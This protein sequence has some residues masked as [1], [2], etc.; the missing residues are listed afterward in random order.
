MGRFRRTALI[1]FVAGCLVTVGSRLAAHVSDWYGTN[2]NL[3]RGAV[4]LLA[5]LAIIVGG[6]F[7]IAGPQKD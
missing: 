3:L 5:Y 1:V 2:P 7:L 6:L 4:Q